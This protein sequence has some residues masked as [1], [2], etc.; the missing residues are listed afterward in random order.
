MLAER[1]RELEDA[2]IVVREHAP[3]PIAVTL[4]R[5]TELGLRLERA[6]LELGAWGAP[7]LADDPSDDTLLGHWL[8]LPLKLRLADR[9]PDG[10]Q[11][12]I[13]LL[14]GNQPI[15]ISAAGGRIDVRLGVADRA[16]AVI[17]GDAGLLLNLFSGKIDLVAAKR[18]GVEFHGDPKLLDRVIPRFQ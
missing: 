17:A 12:R 8:V 6:I 2:G 9:D 18:G 14:A 10:P 13:E 4:F 16:D 5:L 3:A 1:L 15:T 7:L 11:I